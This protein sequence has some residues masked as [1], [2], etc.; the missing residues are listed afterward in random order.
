DFEKGV[1][2][3]RRVLTRVPTK[4]KTETQIGAFVEAET[5]TKSSRRSIVIA[6][7]ALNA[8]KK[9]KDQQEKAKMKAGP[10]WQD[11]DYVFCT[12]VG[13][14]LHPTKDLLD[15]LKKITEKQ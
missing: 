6:S 11:H 1:L 7:F 8:L 14:H 9:Y 3:V 10:L 4:L 13:T 5:K 12:S 2:Q 15:E